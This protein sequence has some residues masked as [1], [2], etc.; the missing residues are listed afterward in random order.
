MRMVAIALVFL[1]ATGCVVQ[2]KQGSE[3]IRVVSSADDCEF[4]GT[5][6]GSGSTGW[7]YA[8]DAE[9]AINDARNKAL[10]LGANAI[11]LDT[12]TTMFGVTAVVQALKCPFNS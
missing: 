2:P 3:M 8:H 6:T 9:G 10:E 5:V 4:L 12:D 7:T 1:L 11:L